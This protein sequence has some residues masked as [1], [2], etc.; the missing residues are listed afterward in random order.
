MKRLQLLGRSKYFSLVSHAAKGEE[1]EEEN[2]ADANSPLLSRGRESRSRSLL[3]NDRSSLMCLPTKVLLLILRTLDFNTLV[4]LCQVNLTLYNLITNEFLFQNVILDSKLSLLKFNALIHSEFHT[5]NITSYSDNCTTQ[6][7]SQNARF[8]VRSIEFKNP[9]SQDSLLKYSKFYNKNGQGSVI[10]GSYK[11]DSY[12]K[13]LTMMKNM[14]LNDETP[15]ITSE[16]IKLLDKFES[17]YFHYTYIELMLDIIDYLPNLTRVVLSEVEPNFKIPLWYSVF[18][19]GSRDFFRKIIKG[20]QSITNEDLRTFQLSKKFVKEYESKYYSLPRLKI[21]EIKAHNKRQRSSNRQ[22]HHQQ[23]VLRPSLFCCFGIINEL[24][25]ENVTIDTES[26]DTPMEFLP[27]F[28]KNENTELYSL[29]S[30]ITALTLNS[31]DIVPG[32]GILRL[33]HSYFRMV[34]HL[35]LLNINSKFDLLLCSC[36]Q[37]L[38]NLTIDCNSNCFTNEQVVSE[39]YYFQQRNIDAEDDFN[40]CNSMT[41]TLFEA[42]SDSKIITPPPTSS[43]VLSLNLKYISRTTGNDVSNNPSPNNNKKPAILTAAQLQTFQRQRIPE[44]HSFYHYYRLLWERLPSKNISINVIN[45]PFTNVYPLSPLSFWEHLASTMSGIDET[46]EDDNDEDDQ[47]TLIGYE[48]NPI[49]DSIPTA[50]GVP[51]LRTVMSPESDVHHTYYWN[52]SVRRCLKDSLVK[53]KNRTIE[54]RDL[55]VEEFLQNV[56]LENFFND[57]QD[58]ENY[59][60]IP[61]INLWCF[62]RNLSK[63]KAVKIRMLRHFSL[64]TPRTRYDWELLL[65]P[66]LRVNVPIE[67]RDKDGFVLYSYGQK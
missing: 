21:L 48:S 8:L 28:L 11:L 29:Q 5:S 46:D 33:F 42:P 66:V 47:E 18:N 43:V 10:A 57:F 34:K 39:S 4:T 32:N 35:S 36:F 50:N 7:K 2:S 16:R 1:E 60:D 56:T 67:V 22:R 44:F 58:P 31:C 51:N 61:N 17:N 13:D 27:L 65:K 19:D 40:D 62:L 63:F 55:D 49:R 59:K 6:S 14:R 25:L 30:P 45:I 64:C 12:D 38:S 23:L 41:E 54:Y 52:N 20:Q 24:K 26:L 9:Q 3:V 53:L 37:S 15:T